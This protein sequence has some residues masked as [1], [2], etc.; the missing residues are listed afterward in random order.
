MDHE[1]KAMF[2]ILNKLDKV[3]KT[4]RMV[5]ENAEHDVELKMAITQKVNENSISVQNYRIDIVL[6]EF[7]GRQKKFYNIVEGDLILHR[8][9]ALFETA[10][11]V[12][13]K[14][15]TNK[16]GGIDDL[17]NFDKEYANNLYEVYMHNSRIKTGKINE[18]VAQAKLDRA[19]QKMYEAKNKILKKL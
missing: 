12:V 3:D 7:A 19:K 14:L 8:E 15:M 10:M 11:G 13:K 2:D 16:N 4:T 9:L 5:A 6:Q 1:T 18:D 17:V